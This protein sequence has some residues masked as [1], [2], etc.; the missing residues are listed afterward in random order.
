[1]SLKEDVAD[2]TLFN[3]RKPTA[4]KTEIVSAYMEDR[5]SR[6]DFICKVREYLR[7]NPI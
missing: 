3:N 6:F 2:I 4:E 7:A 1:M 5:I